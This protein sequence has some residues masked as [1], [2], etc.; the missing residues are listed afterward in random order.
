[1]KT[2]HILIT[3]FVQGIGFRSFIRSQAKKLGLTG[4]VRNLHNGRVEILVQGEEEKIKKLIEACRE[5]PSMAEV[6]DLTIE[7][8]EKNEIFDSFRILK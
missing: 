7:W 8:N 2:A 3:G 4:W 6:D 5:G 1:M